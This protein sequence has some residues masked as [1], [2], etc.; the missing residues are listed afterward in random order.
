[1]AVAERAALPVRGAVRHTVALLRHE[2]R[3]A[4]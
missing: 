4:A 2:A 1:M 3:H